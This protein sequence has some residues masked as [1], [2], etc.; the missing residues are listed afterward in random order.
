[1]LYI[2]NIVLVLFKSYIDLTITREFVLIMILLLLYVRVC[3]IM[4]EIINYKH[5][6]L[7][8]CPRRA[9]LQLLLHLIVDIL[10]YLHFFS[11]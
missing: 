2:V 9:G 4:K 5:K 8:I 7:V 1:M 6:T 3:G 10:D 11:G